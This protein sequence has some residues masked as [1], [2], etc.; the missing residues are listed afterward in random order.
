MES[1]ERYNDQHAIIGRSREMDFK[2]L[3]HID[4]PVWRYLGRIFDAVWLTI[5][6]TVCSLP[7]ITVGAST[8]ALFYVASKIVKDEEGAVTKQFFASFRANFKQA[9]AIWLILAVAGT[10]L[11]VNL[12]FYSQLE[13]SFARV[14]MIVLLVFTYVL[15]MILHY[16][17][18]VL[19]RF[20]NS[21]KNLFV[22][23]FLLAVK[24]FGWT[25][26][27][28]TITVC[29][30]AVSVFVFAGLLMGAVGL[31]ALLDAWILNPIFEQYI[32]ANHLD[33]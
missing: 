5:L 23:S 1:G 3:F 33:E 18:A 14:F 28:I 21:V 20:D 32:E 30:A 15:L 13:G 12:W 6:W 29:I 24:N 25:L 7:I 19:A 31:A 2:S 4:N 22:L 9:T 11:G 17:F 8:T 16:I 10:V 26:L 27:L